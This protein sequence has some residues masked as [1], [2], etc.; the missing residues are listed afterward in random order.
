MFT[1]PP[2]SSAEPRLHNVPDIFSQSHAMEMARSMNVVSFQAF[3]QNTRRA[4]R[5]VLL[6][7]IP[8][9]TTGQH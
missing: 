2:P 7:Q 1:E 5:P 6:I 9:F 4:L 8:I 3:S